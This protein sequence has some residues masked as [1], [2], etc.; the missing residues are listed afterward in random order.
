M[1]PNWRVGKM[2]RGQ[3]KNAPRGGGHQ[4]LL[5]WCRIAEGL[6]NCEAGSF[7]HLGSF[8]DR[9][10]RPRRADAADHVSFRAGGFGAGGAR[11]G[12]AMVTVRL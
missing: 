1:T 9:Q 2:T 11:S 7:V 5:T 3:R 6:L 8:E 12:D 4:R 10:L